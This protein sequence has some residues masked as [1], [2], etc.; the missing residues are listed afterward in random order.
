MSVNSRAIHLT[1]VDYYTKILGLVMMNQLRNEVVN[2]FCCYEVDD[3]QFF[4]ATFTNRSFL[5][6]CMAFPVL[7]W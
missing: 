7:F 4:S 6:I 3:R 2:Q 5:V 1:M